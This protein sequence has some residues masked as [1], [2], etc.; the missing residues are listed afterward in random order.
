MRTYSYN[1]EEA[2]QWYNKRWGNYKSDKWKSLST[3]RLESEDLLRCGILSKKDFIEIKEFIK[4]RAFR[5]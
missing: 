1:I 5:K 3:L 4:E 2:K